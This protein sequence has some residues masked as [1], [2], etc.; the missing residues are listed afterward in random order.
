MAEQRMPDEPTKFSTMDMKTVFI[1]INTEPFVSDFYFP[2][3]FLFCYSFVTTVPSID[4]KL[5]YKDQ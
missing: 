1:Y 4:R 3:T 2:R 5:F